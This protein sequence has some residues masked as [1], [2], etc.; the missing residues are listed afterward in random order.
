MN[1]SMKLKTEKFY[2]E[3]QR[4]TKIVV[5]DTKSYPVHLESGP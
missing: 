5:T 4:V 1:A 2:R 3:K